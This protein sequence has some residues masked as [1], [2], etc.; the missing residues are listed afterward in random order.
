M[1]S[2]SSLMYI[3]A[4]TL[5]LVYV[6]QIRIYFINLFTVLCLVLVY[7]GS[8][9]HVCFEWFIFYLI[10][11]CIYIYTCFIS[12]CS[13][14]ISFSFSF[15]LKT[16]FCSLHLFSIFQIKSIKLYE[17]SSECDLNTFHRF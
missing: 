8:L 9:V 15:F 10:H 7:A 14:F 4:L 2:F 5:F 3:C 6:C 16:K 13:G 1:G 11:F 17:I 12:I